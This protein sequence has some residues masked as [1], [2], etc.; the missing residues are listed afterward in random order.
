MAEQTE[1][2][3]PAL[4][5]SIR[6]KILKQRHA[7]HDAPYW[8]RLDAFYRGGKALLQNQALMSEVFPARRNEHLEIYGERRRR[9]FYINYAGEIV[10]YIVACL[11]EQNV[12]MELDGVE[13]DKKTGEQ[14]L[15]EPYANFIADVSPPEGVVQTLQEFLR[16]QV[17]NALV[18]RC[19]W[20][21]VD[22]PNM[23]AEVYSSLKEQEDKGG[24]SPWAVCL[25]AESVIDWEVNDSRELLWVMV[26]A[27]IARRMRIDGDR[28]VTTKRWTYYTATEWAVYELTRNF[29]TQPLSD[30]EMV[31]LKNAGIHS[32]GKVPVRRLELPH[33]LWA[34]DILESVAREHFNKRN[35]L[36][37][38]EVQSLLPDL[39]E[40]LAPESP[41]AGITI[42]EKQENPDRATDQVR[43]PGYVQQR[44]KDD[45]A[46]F[47]GPDTA[48]FS[49]ARES[50][51]D[52]RDEMHRITYQMA[53]TVDN[54]AAALG[55]SA[56]SKGEDK[57]STAVVLMAIGRFVR[58]HAMDILELVTAGR[59]EKH[60]WVAKG[61]EEFEA[62][63]VGAVIERATA[64]EMVKVPSPTFH[65]IYKGGVAKHIL[66][67]EA[68]PEDK[69]K[70]QDEIDKN[71]SEE[72]FMSGAEEEEEGGENEGGPPKKKPAAG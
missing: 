5:D 59:R 67:D 24:L 20:T 50:C 69:A 29:R 60:K 15:P 45:K 55:R 72:E 25:P 2:Q 9:A 62:I 13:P 53:L 48:P 34:M 56:E 3:S 51:K 10:N 27:E 64:M 65:R 7:D 28:N 37:W 17:T 40:F 8:A 41:G 32:F 52:L 19:A 18:N 39:Y 70:I 36:A 4:P 61:M 57:A 22:M 12:T 58:R 6:A 43:G 26:E 16:D 68:S 33:G 47:V 11:F 35:H 66:G 71:V 46:E 44:G 31:P 1:Q 63:N 42:S 54:S 23:G 14:R 21:L 30:D 49:Q 38:G